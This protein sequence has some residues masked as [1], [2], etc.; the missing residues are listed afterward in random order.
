MIFFADPDRAHERH[1]LIWELTN[2]FIELDRLIRF[3]GSCV[4]L[5]EFTRTMPGANP[6]ALAMGRCSPAQMDERKTLLDRSSNWRHIA[7]RMFAITVW[8]IDALRAALISF[9][10]K[11]AALRDKIDQDYAATARK[12]FSTAFGDYLGALRYWAAHGS[13]GLLDERSVSKASKPLK[14]DLEGPVVAPQGSNLMMVGNIFG[15]KLTMTFEGQMVQL[16]VSAATL[17]ILRDWYEAVAASLGYF[18][19]TRMGSIKPEQ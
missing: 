14:K 12:V 10:N 13:E 11:N 17:D 1:E 5:F 19:E 7:C 4:E 8:E 3:A 18:I 15:N 16:E 6:A 2:K 9:I